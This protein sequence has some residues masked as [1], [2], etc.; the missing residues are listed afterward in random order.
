[1]QVQTP[2]LRPRAAGMGPDTRPPLPPLPPPRRRPL[3]LPQQQGISV[4]LRPQVSMPMAGFASHSLTRS[5]P[6]GVPGRCLQQP[7]GDDRGVAQGQKRAATAETQTISTPAAKRRLSPGQAAAAAVATATAAVRAASVETQTISTP[8]AERRLSPGQAAAAAVATATAAAE[9]AQ[10]V[11][12]W[13]HQRPSGMGRLHGCMCQLV[14][15]LN[16]TKARPP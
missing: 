6:L 12:Q 5:A 7:S 14:I 16:G 2:L 1:M 10:L 9:Q 15:A 8:A 11:P 4:G 3:P 13:C